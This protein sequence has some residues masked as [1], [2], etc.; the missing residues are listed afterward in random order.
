MS[1]LERRVAGMSQAE[2]DSLIAKLTGASSDA[3]LSSLETEL[4]AG[5]KGD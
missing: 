5:K 2:I 4:A 1:L 3:R